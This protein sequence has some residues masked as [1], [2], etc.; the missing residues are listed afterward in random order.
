MTMPGRTFSA[1]AYR[2]GFNGKENDKDAGEGIQD[3]GMR[4]YDNRLGKF[5]SVDPLFNRYAFYSPYHF[6][7]NTPIQAIDVD[8]GEPQAI[9]GFFVG[10][11][12]EIGTQII[13]NGFD[14]L[15]DGKPFWDGVIEKIDWID[16]GIAGVSG[17]IN[18]MLPGAGNAALSKR[19]VNYV[20]SETVGNVAK[21]GFDY[22]IKEGNKNV[23]NG[24][25]DLD[26]FGKDMIVN[27]A[28][29][30]VGGVV[31][32]TQVKPLLETVTT[33][34]T[35]KIVSAAGEV[36]LNLPRGGLSE[37]MTSLVVDEVK[38]KPIATP[39]SPTTEKSKFNIPK[40]N[41]KKKVSEKKKTNSSSGSKDM[42]RYTFTGEDGK[43]WNGYSPDND[44]GRKF[45][46]SMKDVKIIK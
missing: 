26:K 16:V 17:A 14:N 28:G 21:S 8:G 29:S 12:I 24:S 4:I 35:K 36:A 27:T 3:Y 39:F 46:K 38:K 33:T 11:I 19:I 23:L 7:G 2:Y 18:T 5:L 37:A 32:L 15:K 10:A 20:V 13:G 41:E 22:T 42:I 31:P 45:L 25:K 30:I 44:Y 40:K 9:I 34:T 43:T 6:A 1:G